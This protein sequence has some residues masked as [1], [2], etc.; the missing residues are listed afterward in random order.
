MKAATSIL[1]ALNEVVTDALLAGQVVDLRGLGK[2]R[3][4]DVQCQPSIPAAKNKKLRMVPMLRFK[5][6]PTF[7]QRLHAVRRV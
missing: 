2:L 6:S 4:K 3:V 5:P 1:A 7:K